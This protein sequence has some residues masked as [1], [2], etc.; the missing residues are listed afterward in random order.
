M[1][2]L[3]A[4]LALLL[5]GCQDP[6]AS[7]LTI[8]HA[9]G[10]SEADALKAVVKSFQAR[11]PET[12]VLSVPVPYNQLQNKY[13]TSAAANGGPDLLIGNL[14]WVGGFADAGV[15]APVSEPPA[16]HFLPVTLSALRYRDRLW[17][18]PESLET[19]ALYVNKRLARALPTKWSDIKAVPGALYAL[20]IPT[21]F[22]FTAPFLLSPATQVVTENGLGIDQAAMVAWLTWL[23]ELKARPDILAQK[24]YGKADALFKD[25]KVAYLVNGPWAVRDYQKALGE[26]LA[27]VPLPSGLGAPHPFVGVKVFLLNPNT[28]DQKR[29]LVAELV[30]HMTSL[31][32][33]KRFGEAGHLPAVLGSRTGVDPLLTVFQ[34]QAETG[35]PLPVS[36][37]MNV[38]WEPADLAIDEVLFGGVSP[39]AAASKLYAAVRA[40]VRAQRGIE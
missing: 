26:D 24:D 13:L 12:D 2:R 18:Y 31:S 14:D 33:A 1:S 36:P 32:A 37:Y 11:H 19:V 20:A 23:K 40:K 27:V 16:G 7:S 21:K 15:I 8:W 38:V 29:Q 4:A 3:A 25:G 30:Q 10:G 22:Y 9:W 6:A 17:G 34:K 35:I 28:G 5:T 39:E